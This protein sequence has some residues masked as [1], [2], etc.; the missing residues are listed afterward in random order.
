M[1]FI[2]NAYLYIRHIYVCTVRFIGIYLKGVCVGKKQKGGM[3]KGVCVLSIDAHTHMRTPDEG[4]DHTGSYNSTGRPVVGGGI[5]GRNGR[6][7]VDV[8]A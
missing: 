6:V 8:A 2:R 1:A 7:S 4:W 5:K 3:M